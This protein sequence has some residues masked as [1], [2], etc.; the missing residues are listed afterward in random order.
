MDSKLTQPGDSG[1]GS[2]V[3]PVSPTQGSLGGSLPHGPQEQTPTTPAN[4]SAPPPQGEA[5]NISEA[6]PPTASPQYEHDAPTEKGAAAMEEAAVPAG[7][8]P[9]AQK[10]AAARS[11]VRL[12]SPETGTEPAANDEPTAS[13][14][15]TTRQAIAEPATEQKTSQHPI[16][17]EGA[18][19]SSAANEP[20][21]PAHPVTGT[22]DEDGAPSFM[23]ASFGFSVGSIRAR[24][25]I[26]RMLILREG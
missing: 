2:T 17:E 24:S 16:A 14:A 21:G 20:P 1:A 26:A 8:S 22:D 19:S 10:E 5:A 11:D 12:Q 25:S 6:E 7:S 13:E 15:T 23:D 4:S 3:S 9:P 18:S